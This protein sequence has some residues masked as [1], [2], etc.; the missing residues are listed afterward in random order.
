MTPTA[1]GMN[2]DERYRPGST[3]ASELLERLSKLDWRHDE[4]ALETTSRIL[5][6][7]E[8][9]RMVVEHEFAAWKQSGSLPSTELLSRETPTHWKWFIGGRI[10]GPLLWVHEYK[11]AKLIRVGYAQSIHDHRYSFCSSI[12]R[13]GYVHRTFALYDHRVP[14]VCDTRTFVA[15]SVYVL[16]ADVIHSIDDI[17]DGTLTLIVQAP[18]RRGYSTE[19][20][21]NGAEP[22]RHYDF[23]SRARQREV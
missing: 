22:H 3:V 14:T 11:P 9:P 17:Q 13:G 21:E 5:G 6:A 16:H 7:S 23:A 19:Y 2:M 20:F 8:I 18:K 15:P 12:I 10:E 1:S 4:V